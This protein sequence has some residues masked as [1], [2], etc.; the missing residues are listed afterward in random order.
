[1]QFLNALPIE[2][3]KLQ[4]MHVLEHTDL[5]NLYREGAYTPL[6]KSAYIDLVCDCISHL[7]PDIVI[8]RLTGDGDPKLLL[9]PLWSLQKWDVLN[10]IHRELH[11]RH[12]QQGDKLK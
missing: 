6:T 12:I 11:L 7:R 2:G 8:H 4:L 3:V 9:A 10:S 5:A 1:M